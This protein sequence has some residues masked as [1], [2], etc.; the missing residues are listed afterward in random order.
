[1]YQCPMGEVRMI[2]RLDEVHRCCSQGQMANLGDIAT[3]LGPSSADD[4]LFCSGCPS[5]YIHT[6]RGRVRHMDE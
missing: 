5:S 1:M 4:E 2:K 6:E 3:L